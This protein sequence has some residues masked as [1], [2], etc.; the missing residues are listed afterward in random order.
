MAVCNVEKLGGRLDDLDE[1]ISNH[2]VVGGAR[3]VVGG[4]KYRSIKNTFLQVLLSE[5][6]RF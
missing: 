4:Q 3:G 1:G 2:A 5:Y 6:P